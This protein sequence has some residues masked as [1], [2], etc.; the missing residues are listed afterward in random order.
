MILPAALVLSEL[1]DW[2][3]Y[4]QAVGASPEDADAMRGHQALLKSQPDKQ[5]A[6][7]D[8]HRTRDD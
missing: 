3:G 5:H 8:A 6:L 1:L 2:V 7:G 4:L